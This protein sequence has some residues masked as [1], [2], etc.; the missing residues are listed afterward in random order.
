MPVSFPRFTQSYQRFC[1][2]VHIPAW[3]NYQTGLFKTTCFHGI[4]GSL[5]KTETRIFNAL[6][7]LS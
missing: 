2:A 6:K 7:I 3:K 5:I 1:N 4:S